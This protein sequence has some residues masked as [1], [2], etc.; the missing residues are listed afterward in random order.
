VNV[1]DHCDSLFLG[2]KTNILYHAQ[3]P[4]VDGLTSTKMIRS[5]EKT[6]PSHNLS[7]RAALNSRIPVIAVSAS[8]IEKEK[9]TYIDAG[10]DAWILKPIS[11]PRLAELMDGIVDAKVRESC[12]YQPG[13]WEQGGWFDMPPPGR[14]S[15]QANTKPS[16]DRLVPGEMSRDSSECFKGDQI[17]SEDFATGKLGDDIF[18]DVNPYAKEPKNKSMPQLRLPD[19]NEDSVAGEQGSESTTSIF[20]GQEVA[21]PDPMQ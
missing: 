17:S 15:D 6:T 18:S 16:S 14:E 19:Y 8:L 4:I 11:F 20:P 2:K 10:F 9:Q 21:S 1:K 13:K 12:L 5:H 7:K 3:M